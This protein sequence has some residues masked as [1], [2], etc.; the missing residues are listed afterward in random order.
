MPLFQKVVNVIRDPR[1][2]SRKL[3][4]N[5]RLTSNYSK[6]R[7]THSSRRLNMLLEGKLGE[8]LEIGVANGYTIEAL[9]FS[10][11]T[12]VDPLPKCKW[13]HIPEIKIHKMGSD[14]YFEKLD[15]DIKYVGVFLDGAHTF[16]Q[17]YRDAINSM[18]HLE[19]TGFVLFDD[20]V[21]EDEF[22]ALD[23]IAECHKRRK[24]MKSTRE[25]W[26]GDV[27]KTILAIAAHHPEIE[28]RTI[29]TPQHPQTILTWKSKNAVRLTAISDP[30]LDKFKQISHEEIFGDFSTANKIFNFGFEL[31]IIK[32][33]LVL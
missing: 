15:S 25:T 26:S 23:D 21:P 8:Y 3:H 11:K 20:T 24:L 10:K 4:Q 12:G 22:S 33:V 7:G 17:S 27:F 18:N 13:K 5:R 30:E 28:I 16:E 9:S 31:N 14:E 2:I 32:K 6:A 19:A 1:I 29:I